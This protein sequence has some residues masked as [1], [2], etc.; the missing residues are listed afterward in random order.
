MDDQTRHLQTRHLQSLY[1]EM[2]REREL[3]I[4]LFRD[5]ADFYIPRRLPYQMGKDER[6]A[7][8]LLN[9]KIINPT[10]T[11]A[12][13]TLAAGL[14]NGITSPSR[15]WTRL[16]IA[17]DLTEPT[18][19]IAEWLDDDAQ[20]VR[21]VLSE[22]NFYRSIATEYV[23]LS[24]MGTAPGLSYEDFEDVVRFY[25]VSLGEA[26]IAQDHRL[27]I[28][29]FARSIVQT[30][31]QISAWWPNYNASPQINSALRAGGA[32]LRET[33]EICHLIEPNRPGPGA[34]APMFKFREFYWVKGELDR[35]GYLSRAGFKDK[36]FTA[37]RWDTISN[38]AYGISLCAEALPDVK[39]LQLLELRKAKAVDK[40]VD[41]PVQAH[42]SLQNRPSSLLPRGI[43]YVS[44]I[45]E[46]GLRAVFPE[47]RPP[48]DMI[49]EAIVQTENRIRLALHNDLFRGISDLGTV[50]SAVEIEARVREQFVLLG[51]V[52]ARYESEALNPKISRVYNIMKRKGLLSPPPPGLEDQP[53][54]V[55]YRSL[56]GDAARAASTASTER[57]L[58]FMGQLIPV[59]PE[60]RLIPDFEEIVRDYASALN[61][62][63]KQLQTPEEVAGA[64]EALREQAQA[65][66]QAQL[67][68][69]IA[70]GAQ[71]LSQTPVGAGRSALQEVLG[72]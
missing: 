36:P 60:L 1:A 68:N 6:S 44:N 10:A 13:R 49:S 15:P 9:K 64:R 56:M 51:P 4:P 38:D 52:L 40:L 46:G 29:L 5:L 37:P 32:R 26:M 70:Q 14:M 12:L 54:V 48:I 27:E 59:E 47:Y 55:E 67:G 66:A 20:R 58:A 41:P 65:Q 34:M 2:E 18:G 31:S 11:L 19:E 71:T 43:T 8:N 72:V 28:N 42:V 61:L 24:L 69:E 25:N 53:I 3:W 33:F 17:G 22:S 7:R 35:Y 63:A 57:F 39:S 23:D 16:R 62:P 45:A 21:T 50:R 30:V